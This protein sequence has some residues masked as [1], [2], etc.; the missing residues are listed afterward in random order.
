[1]YS[2]T[3]L[4]NL[5]FR[6]QAYINRQWKPSK[7]LYSKTDTFFLE[8]NKIWPYNTGLQSEDGNVFQVFTAYV[9]VKIPGS[10]INALIQLL[11]LSLVDL[12]LSASSYTF[13]LLKFLHKMGDDDNSTVVRIKWYSICKML[14]IVPD[15]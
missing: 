6:D 10:G 8:Y 12:W 2:E 7:A 11:V 3:S 13:L 5:E 1:M 4:L 15:T 9:E 14:R